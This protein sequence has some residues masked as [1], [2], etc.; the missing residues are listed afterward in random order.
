MNEAI[1]RLSGQFVLQTPVAVVKRKLD[2]LAIAQEVKKVKSSDDLGFMRGG[3]PGAARTRSNMSI[4]TAKSGLQ[5]WI[6]RGKVGK[7]LKAAFELHQMIL[8][9][10]IA[11]QTNLYNRLA[12]IAVEDISLGD[13]PLVT[14]ILRFVFENKRDP[15]ELA[16]I[17]EA[18]CLAPKC[19][20]PSHVF[21]VL[22]T[23]EGRAFAKHPDRGENA[24][25]ALV[26]EDS[27]PMPLLGHC[28]HKRWTTEFGARSAR[29]LCSFAHCLGTKDINCFMWLD[30]FIQSVP[31]D[32]KLSRFEVLPGPA[33]KHQRTKHPMALLW[34]TCLRTLMD[35]ELWSLLGERYFSAK[36]KEKRAFLSMAVCVA[37]YVGPTPAGLGEGSKA[38]EVGPDDDVQVGLE[39]LLAGRYALEWWQEDAQL[40][41]DKHTGEGRQKGR[42]MQDFRLVGAHVEN[43]T[44]AFADPLLKHLYETLPP[45]PVTHPFLTTKKSRKKTRV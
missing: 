23:R 7:A 41:Q 42:T 10:C 45:I 12:I 1:A 17:V 3:G 27:P 36:V 21:N 9:G 25:G 11:A 2:S 16:S 33:G 30:R 29:L 8:V 20:L 13:L 38:K 19:R 18:A 37:F 28:L 5:K 32:T 43:E 14:R 4:G 39:D 26:D 35:G 15:A 44:L 22:C 34:T 24:I 6:R 40:I 31:G